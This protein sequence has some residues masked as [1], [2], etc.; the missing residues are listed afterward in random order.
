MSIKQLL[1]TPLP[2]RALSHGIPPNRSLKRTKL[3]LLK[4]RV[5]VLLIALLL[6][7]RILNSTISWSLQP[8]LVSNLHIPKQSFFVSTRSNNTFLPPG[9][10]A[11]C[12]KKLSSGLYRDLLACVCLTVMSF[13]QISGWL[14]CSRRTRACDHEATSRCL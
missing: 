5:A 10:F 13:Q 7:C 2:S 3:P 11:I 12:V 6:P 8:R 1:W 14:K 4:S 9:S